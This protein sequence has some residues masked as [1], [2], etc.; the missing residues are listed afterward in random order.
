MCDVELKDLFDVT[1]LINPRKKDSTEKSGI[2][3]SRL[4][5]ASAAQTHGGSVIVHSS[6]DNDTFLTRLL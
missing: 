1:K 4:H 3:A 5:G 2:P 6:N